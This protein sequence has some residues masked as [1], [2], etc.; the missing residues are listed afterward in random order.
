MGHIAHMRNVSQAIKKLEQ[1]YN[2][3]SSKQVGENLLL[4]PLENI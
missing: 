3:A 2:Y 4:P 1:S